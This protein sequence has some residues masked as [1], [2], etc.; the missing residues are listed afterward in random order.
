MFKLLQVRI[1]S[2]NIKCFEIVTAI[3]TQLISSRL[4]ETLQ[5]ISTANL[6]LWNMMGSH[7]SYLTNVR[8]LTME[9]NELTV[10]NTKTNSYARVANGTGQDAEESFLERVEYLDMIENEYTQLMAEISSS[11]EAII[12]IQQQLIEA[13][14]AA[15]LVSVTHFYILLFFLG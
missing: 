7:S 2:L 8:K 6:T 13:Q 12:D 5:N 14:E 3:A 1:F 10:N 11:K 4:L 9:L 15:A